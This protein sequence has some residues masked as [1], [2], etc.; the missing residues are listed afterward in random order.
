MFTVHRRHFN[1]SD[2]IFVFVSDDMAWG[3]RA[4]AP[5][6]SLRDLYFASEGRPADED[7]YMRKEYYYTTYNGT[8]CLRA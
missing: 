5:R 2:L 3:K 7:R 1:D 4:L 6:N 8:V